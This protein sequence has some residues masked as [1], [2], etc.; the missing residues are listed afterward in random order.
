MPASVLTRAGIDAAEAQAD[1]GFDGLK[2]LG[3]KP[4]EIRD[5]SDVI[6]G[7]QTI[8]GA[9]H[10][11]EE[12]LAVFDCANTC[13]RIGTRFIAAEGH[14]RMMAASQPFLS[15]AISKTINLPNSATI[16]E[17]A[18]SYTMSWELGLKANALY[19]D[20]CKLSQPLNSS[21]D[22]A[23]EEEGE[24]DGLIEAIDEVSTEVSNIAQ[25]IEG[26]VGTPT[27]TATEAV[28]AQVTERVV[29]RPMRRRL[30][31]TRRSLTHRFNVAGHEGYLTV[32]LYDG[33]PGELFITMSKE[34]STIGGLMDSLGTAI[35]VALQYGVPVESLVKK[36]A[37]QRFEPMGMS[38]N[39]EIPFAKS[40]VDYIFRWMGM[41][42]IDG[43]R[44]KNAPNRTNTKSG[45][46][47]ASA[48]NKSK[49]ASAKTSDTPSATITTTPKA[50]IE[51]KAGSNR[52]VAT[53]TAPASSEPGIQGSFD[54]PDPDEPAAAV[55]IA[56]PDEKAARENMNRAMRAMQQDSPPCSVCGAIT[57]RSGTCYK[58]N[59][60]GNSEGCS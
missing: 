46:G 23:E 5:L 54:S 31:D 26:N 49:A 16:E 59:D 29:E 34:G 28:K 51:P 36:F 4:S 37:H 17:V 58:C 47:T 48:T 7:T 15:G 9:P 40:L 57:V 50:A 19:R 2:A 55:A 18:A 6:C 25:T 38:S 35:S 10:L 33:Q 14:I 53:D 32:G 21:S 56:E 1:F 52:S 24:D 3:L 22:A 44:E 30:P 8:E 43:F 11:S 60:C 39:P 41:E 20:G 13:G 42:F 12:H 27:I 45:A